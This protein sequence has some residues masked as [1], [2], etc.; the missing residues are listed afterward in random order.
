MGP[1]IV[2]ANNYKNMRVL[3]GEIND[4]TEMAATATSN[5]II[6]ST[7]TKFELKNEI[8]TEKKSDKF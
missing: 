5:S 8:G 6:K 2:I 4:L 1:N 7:I 3:F